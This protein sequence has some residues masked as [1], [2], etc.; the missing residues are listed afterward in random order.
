[1]AIVP[2][3]EFWKDLWSHVRTRHLK[4]I[5]SCPATMNDKSG[6]LGVSSGVWFRVW[7]DTEN[8]STTT[9]FSSL[10]K[11]DAL[12]KFENYKNSYGN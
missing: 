4:I 3:P 9:L 7:F 1:M 12:A 8:G 5:D 11:A 10:D 2:P 6:F